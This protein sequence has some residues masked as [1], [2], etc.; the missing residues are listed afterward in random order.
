MKSKTYLKKIYD[1]DLI[2]FFKHYE[3]EINKV[4]I[5]Y[6]NKK[7]EYFINLVKFPIDQYC[8]SKRI[9]FKNRIQIIVTP[10]D[11]GAYRY[12]LGLSLIFYDKYK[13]GPYLNYHENL[14]DEYYKLIKSS[15]KE[16]FVGI[17]EFFL[18]E[19]VKYA[20]P[21]DN[22]KRLDR[23]MQWVELK[24]VALSPE[25]LSFLNSKRLQLKFSENALIWKDSNRL[26]IKLSELLYIQHY[27][28]RKSDF[29]DVFSSQKKIFWKRSVE[30]WVYLMS[31]L[32]DECNL[33]VTTNKGAKPYLKIGK[34]FFYFTERAGIIT[35]EKYLS[36]MLYNVCNPKIKKHLETRTSIDSILK[37][38]IAKALIK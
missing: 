25:Q 18:T 32:V 6:R 4:K 10:K 2:S 27:T 36:T 13:I 12:F 1:I 29:R 28:S 34:D 30:S 35:N 22:S 20:S 17:V 5:I 26:L 9:N 21:F 24:K 16:P 37:A 8:K 33:R 14:Y 31:L 3:V 38:A 15:D 11:D 19:L 7:S 23:I